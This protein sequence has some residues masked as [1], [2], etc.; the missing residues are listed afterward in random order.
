MNEVTDQTSK[1]SKQ[2][3]FQTVLFFY[4]KIFPSLSDFLVRN[5]IKMNEISFLFLMYQ[6][7]F[8]CIHLLL[9]IQIINE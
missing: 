2:G 1:T 9:E 3:K 4:I 6:K 7:K 8:P 5:E